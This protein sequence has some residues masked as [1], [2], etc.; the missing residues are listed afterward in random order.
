MNAKILQNHDNMHHIRKNEELKFIYDDENECITGMLSLA[1]L[2]NIWSLN[3][4]G[5]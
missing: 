3:G 2:S 4:K 5:K 1:N